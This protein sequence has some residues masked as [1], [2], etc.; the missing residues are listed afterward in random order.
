MRR[1]RK[2]STRGEWGDRSLSSGCLGA[3]LSKRMPP[4]TGVSVIA[5]M[6]SGP[7]TVVS[8]SSRTTAS[9]TPRS[10]PRTIAN[11]RL[12]TGWG[13]TGLVGR[14]A[15]STT[16][17]LI[18][19]RVLP[20]AVSSS[21]T[22]AVSSTAVAWAICWASRGSGSV[23]DTSRMTVSGTTVAVIFFARSAGV[24]SRSSLS[25]TRPA[26]SWPLTR[27]A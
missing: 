16:V 23:A 18:G 19:A 10:R 25:M 6:S 14:F 4:S 2:A 15:E 7:L 5:L 20:G 24:M 11:P 3:L 17:A 12:R 22:N 8:S 1:I 21:L 9:P 26:S 13:E 27:S